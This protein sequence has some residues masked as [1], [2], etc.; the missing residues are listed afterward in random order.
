MQ[1]TI[2]TRYSDFYRYEPYLS[3][4]SKEALK[5]AALDAYGQY[6]DLTIERFSHLTSLDRDEVAKEYDTV[7]KVYWLIGF[8]DFVE[9]F[10]KTLT[11]LTLKPTPM[12]A[13]ASS[14]CYPSTMIESMLVFSRSYFGLKSFAEAG[15]VTLGDYLIARKDDYNSKAFERRINE[16]NA[17]KIKNHSK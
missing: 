11:N 13:S 4:E 17:Q 9:E 3:E 16:L 2:D 7:F 6:T 15:Q 5:K 10:S 1:I 8:K 14:V 12:E